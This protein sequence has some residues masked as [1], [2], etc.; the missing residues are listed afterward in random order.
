MIRVA[1]LCLYDRD[2][3]APIVPVALPPGIE[4]SMW[5]SPA[6]ASGAQ[7]WYREAQR[8]MREGQAVAVA[9]RGTDVV[10]YCWL[11]RA[12]EW[13]AEIGRRVVPG[14]DEVYLYDA[15]TVP[16]WRGHRLFPAMLG[17]LVEYA[18]TQGKRRALIFVLSRNRA[19]RRAI[20]RGGFDLFQAVS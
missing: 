18:R 6:Q 10:A 14:P 4:L 19:S 13:V 20:E 3:G 17:A 15:F 12:P 11:T 8:R 7:A 5:D 2:I 1:T 16:E 9:R